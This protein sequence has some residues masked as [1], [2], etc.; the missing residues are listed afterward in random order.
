MSYLSSAQKLRAAINGAGAM[1]TDEQALTVPINFPAWRGDG[2]SYAAGDRVMYGGVLNKC[3]Q[4]HTS[5]AAWT[6]T[7]AP[8]ALG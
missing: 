2:I 3:L 5:Q 4:A 1:L 8:S 7:D 6:P